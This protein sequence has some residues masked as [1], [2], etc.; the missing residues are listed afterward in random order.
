MNIPEESSHHF[1]WR[2]HCLELLFCWRLRTLPGH[3]FCIALRGVSEDPGLISCNSSAYECF[4]TV[5]INLAKHQ[6]LSPACIF[7]FSSVSWRGTHVGQTSL[8]SRRSWSVPN[9]ASRKIKHYFQLWNTRLSTCT[10]AW[11]YGPGSAHV[12]DRLVLCASFTQLDHSK[13]ACSIYAPD[14][15]SSY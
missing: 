6:E 2:L 13:T 4:T 15:L 5:F 7:F 1:P 11:I 10:L 8:Q 9:G 14:V 3:R 12:E